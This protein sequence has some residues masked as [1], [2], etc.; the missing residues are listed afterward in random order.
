VTFYAAPAASPGLTTLLD[1][2]FMRHA[3][4]AGTV[5]AVVAG[6]VG[7]L[8]LLRGQVFTGDALSHASFTGALAA[9]AAGV[10]L[11]WGLFT[12]TITVAVVLA[13]LGGRRATDDV[14]IGSVFAW[15][16]GLGV[17]FLGIYTSSSNAGNG[18]AGVGVLFGSIFGLGTG[19]VQ[20][21]TVAGVAVVLLV[22]AL[23]RPLLFSSVDPDVAAAHGVPVRALGVLF[24]MLVGVAAAE[25]TQAVGA[26]LLLGLLTAPAG[27]ALRCTAR[28]YA[29]LALSAGFALAAMWAGLVI[30]YLA[31]KVP[32]S[33]AVIACASGGYAAAALWTNAVRVRRAH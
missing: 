1:Q 21:V 29:G 25:A 16:L 9:L 12:A 28:P 13:L 19:D 23:L 14:V 7:Y 31:P 32:P 2:D 11:R 24:L 3:L 10:D 30:S 6:V 18:T 5:V 17:L 26:L 8:L 33:F 20:V 27:T 15:L 22:L 4:L